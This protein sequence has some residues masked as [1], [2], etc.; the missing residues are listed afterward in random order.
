[1]ILLLVY[2]V[3]GI[4]IITHFFNS[5]EEGLEGWEILTIGL[6]WPFLFVMT[7]IELLANSYI[8]RLEDAHVQ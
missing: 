3:V 4:S 8:F 5:P 6:I 7:F 1:M 2:Y